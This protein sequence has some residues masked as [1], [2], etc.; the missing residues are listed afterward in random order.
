MPVELLM[1]ENRAS[2]FSVKTHP[3]RGYAVRPLP[4]SALVGK[5]RMLMRK[6]RVARR[7]FAMKHVG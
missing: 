2:A 3:Y 5:V 6:M 7:A 4:S 1:V